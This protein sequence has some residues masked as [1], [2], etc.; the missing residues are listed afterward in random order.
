MKYWEVPVDVLED[1][2]K[3]QVWAQ[4]A[5]AVARSTKKGKKRK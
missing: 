3:L 5:I 1:P 2:E 4:T